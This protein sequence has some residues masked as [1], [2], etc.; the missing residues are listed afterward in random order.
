MPL[1]SGRVASLAARF[2]GQVARINPSDARATLDRVIARKVHPSSV[3]NTSG[4]VSIRQAVAGSQPLPHPSPHAAS[5]E[6][7][8]DRRPGDTRSAAEAIFLQHKAN[9]A[10]R[11]AMFEKLALDATATQ[12]PVRQDRAAIPKRLGA[13]IYPGVVV[14]TPLD[15]NAVPQA[16]DEPSRAEVIDRPQ[17]VEP[18]RSTKHPDPFVIRLGHVGRNRN[19][20]LPTR[21]TS[22][23]RADENIASSKKFSLPRP[24]SSWTSPISSGSD[25]GRGSPTDEI[26]LDSSLQ[27]DRLM[28]G[29]LVSLDTASSTGAPDPVMHASVNK[30]CAEWPYQLPSTSCDEKASW[31]EFKATIEQFER[32]VANEDTS[33]TPND[34][35]ARLILAMAHLSNSNLQGAR[36]AANGALDNVIKVLLP[37]DSEADDVASE[38]TV[39]LPATDAQCARE[40]RIVQKE[41][42]EMARKYPDTERGTVA[43]SLHLANLQRFKAVGARAT[44]DGAVRVMPEIRSMSTAQTR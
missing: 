35:I 2:G 39:R 22:L 34:A 30:P 31:T 40:L 36:V 9:F 27:S 7:V 13:G 8:Q 28:V 41:L 20:F 6:R 21:E 17:T 32:V 25:S 4:D 24:V 29:V 26:L 3:A 23:V 10:T 11:R 16:D 33:R 19:A 38:T 44:Y 42:L 1:T 43:R 12:T 18:A 5:S 14:R 15:R 37:L